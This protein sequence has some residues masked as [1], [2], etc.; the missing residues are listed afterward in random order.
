MKVFI[1]TEK[2]KNNQLFGLFFV[3]SE[4]NVITN[5]DI[6]FNYRVAKEL[7]EICLFKVKYFQDIKDNLSNSYNL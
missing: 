7:F 3:I 5:E 6:F 1:I 2:E 4:V